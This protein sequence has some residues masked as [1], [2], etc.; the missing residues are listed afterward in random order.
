MPGSGPAP[1]PSISLPSLSTF[2]SVLLSCFHAGAAVSHSDRTAPASAEGEAGQSANTLISNHAAN[3]RS[4]PPVSAIL[5][6][7][8]DSLSAA[9]AAGL[10][11]DLDFR[12][13]CHLNLRRQLVKTSAHPTILLRY[14]QSCDPE[15][16][17]AFGLQ[18]SPETQADRAVLR[19][20]W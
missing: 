19:A 20:R 5:N 17:I 14:R 12:L 11:R 7:I 9:P 8:G 4:R 10:Q 16:A 3:T 15:V 1:V 18:W 13:Q 6:C 2:M